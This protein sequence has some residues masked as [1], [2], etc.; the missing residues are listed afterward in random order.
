MTFKVADLCRDQLDAA[1][2]KVEQIYVKVDGL[3]AIYRT[4]ERIVIQYADDQ[5]Q[6]ADQR[7]SLSEVCIT[8]GT[9]DSLLDE[10]RDTEDPNRLKRARRYE[11]RLVDALALGLQGQTNSASIEMERLKQDLVEER[12]SGSRQ[13]YLAASLAVGVGLILL[14]ALFSSSLFNFGL[15][16]DRRSVSASMWFSAAVGTVGAFCSTA[17]AIRNREI[18]PSISVRDTMVD[19]GLRMLVGAL[20]GALLY[21]L[22]KVGAFGLSV[23]NARIDG[24]AAFL[25]SGS[26]WLLVLLVAFVAG[27]LE[28]LVPNLLAKSTPIETAGAKTSITARSAAEDAASTERNP[29]GKVTGAGAGAAGAAPFDAVSPGDETSDDPE[30]DE[31]DCCDRPGTPDLLTQDIELPEAL[32]GVEEAPLKS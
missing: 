10:L 16:N 12:R 8:R 30:K 14:I 24:N 27:F 26:G 5:V 6:G 32:G 11:R 4:N 22:I 9:I 28:R 18:E 21:A 15:P 31:D 7:K 19:A 25:S 23:G 1:G 20:S 2:V 29:L 17:L 3:Y 13:A